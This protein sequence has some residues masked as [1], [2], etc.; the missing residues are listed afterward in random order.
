MADEFVQ[1]RSRQGETALVPL[2]KSEA[3]RR[4]SGCLLPLR[5]SLSNEEVDRLIGWINGTPCLEL[6]YASL[7]AAVARLKALCD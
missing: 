7:E 3:L 4:L 6:T 1:C 5:G 2:S